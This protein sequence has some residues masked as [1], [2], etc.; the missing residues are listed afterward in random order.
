[1]IWWS[2]LPGDMGMGV[3]HPSPG[4]AA[5]RQVGALGSGRRVLIVEDDEFA[6]FAL[7]EIL[8]RLGCQATTVGSI[9]G[10]IEKL[11][12]QAFDHAVV[13]LM[14]PDG[15]GCLV[16]FHIRARGLPVQV[17]IATASSDPAMI[18]RAKA[19][20]PEEVMFKPL[21]LKRL[22]ERMGLS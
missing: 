15:E 3:E 12:S 16:L 1:M 13:D 5:S 14:L 19:G 9:A 4:E 11:E 8:R 22:L 17:I 21:N 20:K 6:A 18:E 10:A 2:L 7:S